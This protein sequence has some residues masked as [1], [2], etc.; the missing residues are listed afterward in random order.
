VGGAVLA[1]KDRTTA[2]PTAPPHGLSLEEVFYA[3]GPHDD[4]VE[5]E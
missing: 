4:E 3:Q 1:S 5:D 2:G